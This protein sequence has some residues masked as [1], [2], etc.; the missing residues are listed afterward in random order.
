MK[1]DF[2][3]F[4]LFN[5]L[6]AV[7]MTVVIFIAGIVASEAWHASERA[8]AYKAYVSCLHEMRERP[9]DLMDSF[10]GKIKERL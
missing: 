8:A 10:C 5:I 1:F 3:E 7:I 9:I 6:Y 4:T 2:A